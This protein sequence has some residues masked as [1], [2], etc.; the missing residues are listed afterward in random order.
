MLLPIFAVIFAVMQT[1]VPVPRKAADN[2]TQVNTQSKSNSAPGQ[3]GVPA[4]TSTKRDS[5]GPTANDSIQQG[6][7]DAQ[8]TVRIS[9]LP[10]ISVA[11]DWADWGVWVFSLLL[12]IVGGF[13]VWLLYK[14]LG[15]ISIQ[16]D[17]MEAQTT[18]LGES[19]AV[20]RDNLEL[21]IN[22]ERA[23]IR[24]ELDKPWL[25]LGSDHVPEFPE[26]RYKVEMYGP[27]AAFIEY[28]AASAYTAESIGAPAPLPDNI[29]MSLPAVIKPDMGPLSKSSFIYP[30]I[31]K[32]GIENIWKGKSFLHF[33]GAIRYKDV[34]GKSRRTTFKYA[35]KVGEPYN[36]GT[37]FGYWYKCGSREDNEET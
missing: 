2:P 31:D 4:P 32:S 24:L 10:P 22:K 27:T 17:Q 3:K 14:T 1:A 34:F 5:N 12:V 19:I 35:W 29:P 36:D 9:K 23:R 13:Q 26:I 30:N 25:E 16:A 28:E 20:A 37:P 21:I 7:N 33:R 15:S 8:H 18:K 6:Q 11:R